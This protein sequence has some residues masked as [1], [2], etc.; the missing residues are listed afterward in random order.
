MKRIVVKESLFPAGVDEIWDKLQH[1]STLQ[2]VAAPYVSFKPM[3]G[4][5]DFQWQESSLFSLRFKLFGLIPMGVHTIRILRFDKEG[6]EIYSNESNPFIP[7]WNHRIRLQQIDGKHTKYMDQVEIDAGLKTP[8][9]YLWA[10]AFY[11]HR[12]RKWIQLL[13]L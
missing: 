6:L 2:F 13:Q 8:F 10:S 1:L 4:Q 11:S 12:Q 5:L 3:D 7:V 9:V